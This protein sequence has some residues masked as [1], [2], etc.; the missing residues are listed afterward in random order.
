MDAVGYA[1]SNAYYREGT[2]AD[3][4]QAGELIKGIDAGYLLADKAYDTNA[5]LCHCQEHGIE[6]VIPAKRHR[7]VQRAYDVD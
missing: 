3:Y 1:G 7:K 5:I 4:R 6:P 2:A